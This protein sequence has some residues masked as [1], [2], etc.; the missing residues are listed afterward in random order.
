[1]FV[2]MVTTRIPAAKVAVLQK[3]LPDCVRF[4]QPLKGLIESEAHFQWSEERNLIVGNF[5]SKAFGRPVYISIGAEQRDRS[6]LDGKSLAWIRSKAK[7]QIFGEFHEDN[8]RKE[9]EA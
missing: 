9:F 2:N 5:W 8:S 4:F 1:M 7:L 6:G 3:L